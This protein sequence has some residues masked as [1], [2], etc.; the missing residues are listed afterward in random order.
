ML[1]RIRK[2]FDRALMSLPITQHERIWP[3]YIKF[4]RMPG[5][6]PEVACRIYRRFT[7]LEYEN[8]EERVKFLK[9]V[10]R[11]DE[12]AILLAK[13]VLYSVHSFCDLFW[14]LESSDIQY[15]IF[16]PP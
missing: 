12:A 6:P 9:S 4:V 13:Y 1:T 15:F 11:L 5:V 16:V 10:G 3:L 7:M 14:L 8:L 2:T